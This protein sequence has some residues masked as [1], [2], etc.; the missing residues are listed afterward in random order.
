MPQYAYVYQIGDHHI[1]FTYKNEMIA[2]SPENLSWKGKVNMNKLM[3]KQ[4]IG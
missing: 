1:M 2:F 3:G 4:N